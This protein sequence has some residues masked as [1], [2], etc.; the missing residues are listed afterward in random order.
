MIIHKLHSNSLF[1][2]S[3]FLSVFYTREFVYNKMIIHKL[4]SNSLFVLSCFLSVFYVLA[5]V[6][7][8]YIETLQVDERLRRYT[9]KQ[10]MT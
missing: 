3:G 5:S 10:R 4:H 8:A 7:S 1:V 9:C 6:F 2:F